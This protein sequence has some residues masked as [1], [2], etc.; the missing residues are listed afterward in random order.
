MLKHITLQIGWAQNQEHR[1]D[2]MDQ[3]EH[4]VEHPC[5]NQVT[6]V[7]FTF[8]KLTVTLKT[9]NFLCS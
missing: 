7:R 4:L 8:L 5:F 3:N 1:V 2:H 9:S 6:W